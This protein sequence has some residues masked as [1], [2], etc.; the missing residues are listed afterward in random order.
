M[1]LFQMQFYMLQRNCENYE[2]KYCTND[3]LR[4]TS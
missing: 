2:W 3:E 1:T 4:T